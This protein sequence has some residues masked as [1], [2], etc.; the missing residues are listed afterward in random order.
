MD[1]KYVRSI[2]FWDPTRDS[3]KVL[4]LSRRFQPQYERSS[5]FTSSLKSAASLHL[6]LFYLVEVHS[7]KKP[8][9]LREALPAPIPQLLSSSESGQLKFMTQQSLSLFPRSFCLVG[10]SFESDE[11]ERKKEKERRA[12]GQPFRHSCL[13]IQRSSFTSFHLE[14]SSHG[15]ETNEFQD[16]P[17][18]PHS[19][20]PDKPNELERLDSLS[21]ALKHNWTVWCRSYPRSIQHRGYY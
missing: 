19:F 2:S 9:R 3:W 17:N 10:W 11:W 13:E 7:L 1:Q 15:Q 21:W 8:N 4:E 16:C 20:L 12:K 18:V 6:T 14:P 5:L